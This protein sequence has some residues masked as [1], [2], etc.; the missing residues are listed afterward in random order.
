MLTRMDCLKRGPVQKQTFTSDE[1]KSYSFS[2]CINVNGCHWNTC[3]LT[4]TNPCMDTS[5]CTRISV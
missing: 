4:F 1:C 3:K 2:T 5:T